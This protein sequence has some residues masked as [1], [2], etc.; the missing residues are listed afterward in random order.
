MPPPNRNIHYFSS[1][2]VLG[3][4]FGVTILHPLDGI[5]TIHQSGRL[6]DPVLVLTFLKPAASLV[7]EKQGVSWQP[8]LTRGSGSPAQGW[9]G[10]DLESSLAR[11]HL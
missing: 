8:P 11:W 3:K 7:T 9:S 1:R 4:S 10:G 6:E 2:E 5:Y